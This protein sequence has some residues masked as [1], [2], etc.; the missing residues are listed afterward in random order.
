VNKS[1]LHDVT[2]LTSSYDGYS[3]L[4]EPHYKLL[5][6]YW[7][8][9]K[10]ELGFIPIM[11]ITNKLRYDDPRVTSLMIEDQNWSKNLIEALKNIKTKYVFL[12]FDDYIVNGPVN[13][14]RFIELLSLME[15]RNGAYIEV[16][17]DEGHFKYSNEK[18]KKPLIGIEGVIY[19]S[20]KSGCRNSL[21]AAI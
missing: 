7:P 17:I 14:K 12:L 20:K 4:W 15:Q 5:F 3:E 8:S 10:N 1:L 6:K 19:R 16:I 21:Q 13:E 2:I 9:L 18:E 11:L